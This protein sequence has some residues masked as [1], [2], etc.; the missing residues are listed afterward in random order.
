MRSLLDVNV[1]VSLLDANHVHHSHCMRWLD[2][3]VGQHHRRLV[4]LDQSVPTSAV[5]GAKDRHLVVID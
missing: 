2:S 3:H 5:K 1:L 4:T